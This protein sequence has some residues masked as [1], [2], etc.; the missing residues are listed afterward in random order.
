MRFL[1]IY[2]FMSNIT[3]YPDTRDTQ[4]NRD[5]RTRRWL[6]VLPLREQRNG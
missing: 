5:H 4:S 2:D 6:H 1:A 3:I